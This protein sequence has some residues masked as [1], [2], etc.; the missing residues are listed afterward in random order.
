MPALLRY[1]DRNSMAHSREVRLP[2]LDRRIAELAFSLPADF[3]YRG[4]VQKRV[5]RDAVADKVP[6]EILTP[7][8]KVGFETPEAQWLAEPRALALIGERLLDDDARTAPFLDR[9]ALGEDVR[10]GRLRDPN[11]VWRLLNLELWLEAV[12]GWASGRTY[13]PTAEIVR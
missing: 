11:G 9:A 10:G 3:L 7:R 1:A 5:L 6:A 13:E 2:F 12:S 8:D 4:G